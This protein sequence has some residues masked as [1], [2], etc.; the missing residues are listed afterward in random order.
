[1]RRALF[2][3]AAVSFL[4]GCV[5]TQRDVISL[6]NQADELKFQVLELKK[7]IGS[8][9]TN[10]ADMI[11]EMK[12][13]H[14]D[15]G[16][17]TETVKDLRGDME[18]LGSKI[19]DVSSGVANVGTGISTKVSALGESLK[20]DVEQQKKDMQKMERK[21]AQVGAGTSPTE[22]FLTA[23]V[24]LAK[25]DYELAAKGF[26]EYAARFPTGSLIDVAV[27]NLGEA[28]FGMGRWEA[29]GR[30]FATAL[31]RFPNSKMTP[32][33]RLMYALCLIRLRRN[34]SEA[35]QYLESIPLD[36]PKSPE[37]K[38]AA[39]HLRKLPAE[40]PQRKGRS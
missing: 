31:E 2:L 38:A 27:Y 25:K 39:E 40:R 12:Q 5:A 16:V 8:M 26:E 18:R 28:Y 22:L 6:E 37:A 1:M 20:E 15:L 24:R 32:S 19:D 10:Q 34:I 11:V 35:K 30:Q 29:A 14:T 17:F 7:T 3:A 36:F 9:Q 13:L 4:T 21:V 33:T 23:E